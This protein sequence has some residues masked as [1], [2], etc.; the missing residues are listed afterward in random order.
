METRIIKTEKQYRRYLAEVARLAARDPELR[1]K[2]GGRLEL[3]AKLIEDYEKE[4]FKFQKPDPVE[5]ITRPESQS[6]RTHRGRSC[7][8]PDE[9]TLRPHGVQHIHRQHR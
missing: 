5:A 6:A 1:S 8:G 2:E 4:R 7:Q 9:R 3:L